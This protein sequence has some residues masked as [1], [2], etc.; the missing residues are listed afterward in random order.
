MGGWEP[1]I[2]WFAS[3]PDGSPLVVFGYHKFHDNTLLSGDDWMEFSLSM[4]GPRWKRARKHTST[5]RF[6]CSLAE[7]KTG[8]FYP[9]GSRIELSDG[10]Y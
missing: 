1:L 4:F 2:R 6:L 7:T 5:E 8:V 3:N 9:L 10:R